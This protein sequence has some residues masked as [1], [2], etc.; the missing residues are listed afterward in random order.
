MKFYSP[1]DVTTQRTLLQQVYQ[2]ISVR[3]SQ[4][5]SF[6]TPPKL[7]ED[8]ED[9]K[10]IYRHYATLYFVFIVDDQESE[11][12][13][14]DLIQVFVECLDKCFTN[15]CELDLVF[16]WQVLQTVLEEIVQGG[17]V[18]DTNI[19]RIVSAVDAANS[20]KVTG[21]NGSS[22]LSGFENSFRWK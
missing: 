11:L 12:G 10:V 18:I 8:L 3:T 13:I 5:C 9:I 14:L 21:V 7:L 20:Q 15:V 2:L 6:I 19:S 4:E 22:W 16:G 1:L 17:M